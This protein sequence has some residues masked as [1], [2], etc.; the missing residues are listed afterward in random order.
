MK[1]IWM[2]GVLG[3]GLLLAVSMVYAGNGGGNDR[4]ASPQKTGVNAGARSGV[5]FVD[6]NGD[7]ICDHFQ[8]SSRRRG[9]GR[10]SGKG[11]GQMKAGSRGRNYVDENGDGVCDNAGT[12]INSKNGVKEAP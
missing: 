1:W 10:G 7:G 6:M 5:N 11:L 12:G 2:I 8:G 9:L 4:W 3:L